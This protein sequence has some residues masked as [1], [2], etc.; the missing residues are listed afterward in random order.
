MADAMVL[1]SLPALRGPW[2]R[3]SAAVVED[4]AGQTS[5]VKSLLR[6][7]AERDRLVLSRVGDAPPRLTGR[8]TLVWCFLLPA[9]SSAPLVGGLD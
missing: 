5:G 2:P 1:S 8:G 3:S 4:G 7:G 9:D 6:S